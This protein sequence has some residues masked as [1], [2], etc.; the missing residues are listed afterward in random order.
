MTPM[1]TRDPPQTRQLDDM[2]FHFP[3]SPFSLCHSDASLGKGR[4]GRRRSRLTNALS[5]FHHSKMPGLMVTRPLVKQPAKS[6]PFQ[7]ACQ[8]GWAA[9]HPR[10]FNTTPVPSTPNQ[11]FQVWGDSRNGP[12]RH[13]NTSSQRQPT[14]WIF[15]VQHILQM[16]PRDR[17]AFVPS[18]RNCASVQ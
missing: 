6:S 8:D 16:K 18:F 5:H 13:C 9:G 10:V 3:R 2:G 15:K 17:T 1:R 12:S 4:Q 14:R 11:P 7:G